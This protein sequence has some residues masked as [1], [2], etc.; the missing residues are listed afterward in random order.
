MPDKY[1]KIL[2]AVDGSEHSERAFQEAISVAKRNNADLLIVHIFDDTGYFHEAY[3][4]SDGYKS[5]KAHMENNLL[6][7]RKR[8]YVEGVGKAE[9]L[10]KI[11]RSKHLIATVIPEERDIDLIIMGVT[12]LGTFPR[13]LLGSTTAYVVNHAPCNV[14]VVR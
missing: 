10:L 5:E 8:A 13:L 12:G 7:K 9:V 14:L 2:V 1:K 4:S 11:G 6:N 3:L